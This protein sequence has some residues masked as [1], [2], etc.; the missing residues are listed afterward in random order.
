MTQFGS[1]DHHF[2]QL[3]LKLETDKFQLMI[4]SLNKM[5][6]F[7]SFPQNPFTEQQNRRFL[8]TFG[9]IVVYY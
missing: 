2:C 5:A 1:N 4:N 7:L 8:N 9:F 6:E 3:E